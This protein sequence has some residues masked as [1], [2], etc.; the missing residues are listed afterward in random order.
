M[1]YNESM[2]KKKRPRYSSYPD[3]YSQDPSERR[4][5]VWL[6]GL[7]NRDESDLLYQRV[8]AARPEWFPES[9]PTKEE[10]VLA[11][12]RLGIR[13]C[14]DYQKLRFQDHR[15]PSAP[16]SCYKSWSWNLVEPKRAKLGYT[17]MEEYVSACQRFGIRSFRDHVREY[18]KHP[19]LVSTPKNC[20][21]DWN[22][23]LLNG[24]A[25][26]RNWD[27]TLFR[28]EMEKHGS[29]GEFRKYGRGALAW[30]ENFGDTELQQEF[31]TRFPKRQTATE[32]FCIR[33]HSRIGNSSINGQCRACKNFRERKKRELM[34]L[35]ALAS[36]NQELCR[37]AMASSAS[38]KE[39]RDI[40]GGAHNWLKH[41]NLL[42]IMNEERNWPKPHYRYVQGGA[43]KRAISTEA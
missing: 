28:A 35:T 32:D 4:L 30:L 36:W 41:N 37:E 8:K 9:Y 16:Q 43:N 33:G 11:C 13:T 15:L 14:R 39:F 12:R 3:Y 7:R 40:F 42:Y 18:F 24:T 31:N 6:N 19:G 5:R 20:F 34:S 25:P 10:V 2:G 27:S 26:R 38:S 22:W 1:C 29:R 17:S 23:G 21:P